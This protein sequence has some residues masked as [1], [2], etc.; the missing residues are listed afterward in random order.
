MYAHV[1]FFIQFCI[2]FSIKVGLVY[3]TL[4]CDVIIRSTGAVQLISNKEL[5]VSVES[6][7]CV[8]YLNYLV[9][10]CQTNFS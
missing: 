1:F 8:D 4:T 7:W 5:F 9:Q 6:V 2:Y 10:G 3:C